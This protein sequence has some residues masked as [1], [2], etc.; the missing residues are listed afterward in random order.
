MKVPCLISVAALLAASIAFARIP[1]RD[2]T[3]KELLSES[4]LVV[5]ANALETKSVPNREDM[6]Q[7]GLQKF[8]YSFQQVETTF[9]IQ[10]ILK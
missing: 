8:P 6:S 10:V 9:R 2:W 4:D 7:N 1:N 3:Y 5:I